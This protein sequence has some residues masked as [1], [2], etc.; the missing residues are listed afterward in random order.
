MSPSTVIVGGSVGGIRTAQALRSNGYVGEVVVIDAEPHV[1]YDKPP[2]SKSFLDNS[3]EADRIRLI[4][5]PEVVES[6]IDLRLGNKAAGVD[7]SNRMVVL[8]NGDVVPYDDLVLATGVRARPSPWEASDG[9]HLLRTLDDAQRLKEDLAGARS[10]VIV[11]AG[12]IGAE[13]AATVKKLGLEVA[14]VDPLEI[15]IGQVL[16]ADVGSRFV[17]LHHANG[18]ATH[19][20]TGV[21]FITGSRGD[22]VVGLSNGVE[23]TGDVVVVGI[24]AVPNV[25]WLASSGLALDNGLVCDEYCRAVGQPNVYGVG[26]IARW[27]HP[28][29]KQLVRVEHWTNAVE[30]AVCVA[31]NIVRPSEPTSYAPIPYV[32]SD[33]YDWKIQIAG[34]TAMAEDVV[35]IDDPANKERFAA[36]YGDSKGTYCGAA[37]VNWPRA[38]VQCRRMLEGEFDLSEPVGVLRQMVSSSSK[39][40]S[41]SAD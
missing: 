12:F 6:R 11:G 33:Q 41:A 26:D 34:E 9:V 32:W 18:V 19:Y 7:L 39:L 27:F 31:K 22:L 17:G 24:G 13:V 30:Q 29:K 35:I 25:E 15:P 20:G 14:V 37:T 28:R 4:S 1:P 21:D 10:A 3:L 40:R 16:G 5:E 36:V 2:L 8:E 23:L 38:M